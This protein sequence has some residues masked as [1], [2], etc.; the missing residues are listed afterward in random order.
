M[1]P[2]LFPE[3]AM[4]FPNPPAKLV[5]FNSGPVAPHDIGRQFDE[6]TRSIS[7]VVSFLRGIVRDDGRLRN[8][9][10]GA[11]QLAPGLPEDLAKRAVAGVETLLSDVRH[12]ADEAAAAVSEAW[13]IREQLENLHVRIAQ[14]VDAMQLASAEARQHLTLLQRDLEE[15]RSPRADTS[16]TALPTGVL[17]PNVGGPFG[18]DPQGASATAQDYSQ[19]AIEWAEHMPDTIPPNILAINAITGQHWSSRWWASRA[20]GMFGGYLVWW[21]LGAYHHA[22][23]PTHTPTGDP[24]QPG[25]LYYDIDLQQMMVWNGT[26]W[27]SL[28]APVAG[29]SASLYYLTTA[30][31]SV[32]PLGTADKFGTTATLQIGQGVNVYLNGVR[33]TPLDD[34]S[35]SQPTSTITL[36]AGAPAGLILAIDTLILPAQL[37]HSTALVKALK[38]LVP[39]PD[40]ATTTFTLA[41]ADGATLSINNDAQAWISVDGVP[42]QPTTAYTIVGNQISFT[43]APSA[44]AYI[45]GVW[46]SQ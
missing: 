5:P 3:C 2:A 23:A 26:T 7:N 44:D 14:S 13:R 27:Q 20:A 8:G 19:V 9:A 1:V 18:T 11:E 17:G 28:G 24:L 43:T 15:A 22:D 34:Y 6:H 40:G 42:Q 45:F 46:F 16:G 35:V 33:L 29:I 41:S 30:G 25:M 39:V 4:S 21:Y 38:P 10:I 32:Y 36:T 12:S 31:Q 37:A